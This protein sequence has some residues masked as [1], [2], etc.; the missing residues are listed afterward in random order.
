MQTC[1]LVGTFMVA[2]ESCIISRFNI[3]PAAFFSIAVG[4][5]MVGVAKISATVRVEEEA[6]RTSVP[7]FDFKCLRY[8]AACTGC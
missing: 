8:C 4:G 2:V 5:V 3:F 6:A 1:P 7:H